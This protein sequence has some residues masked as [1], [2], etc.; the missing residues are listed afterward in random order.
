MHQD[1]I[2]VTQ[3]IRGLGHACR[4]GRGR[5]SARARNQEERMLTSKIIKN[6][7]KTLALA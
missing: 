5:I 1:Y 3:I 4:R 6:T 2:K 7:K